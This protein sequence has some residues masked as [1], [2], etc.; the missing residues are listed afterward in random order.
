MKK[1]ALSAFGRIIT[2]VVVAVLLLV[3]SLNISTL[4]SLNA[5]RGGANVQSGYFCAIIGS[6]SMEPTISVHDFLIIKG[7]GAYREGDIV[8]Y[9]S[10][11]GSLVTH[12][13]IEVSDGAYIAQGDANNVP[14]EEIP[15]QRVLGKVVFLIPGV[16][17]VIEAVTAP[18]GIVLSV[19]IFLLVLLIQWIRR[20]INEDKLNEK[21]KANNH[22]EN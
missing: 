18:I 15:G 8:T 7:S 22:T 21:Q 11:K 13:I 1:K 20:D 16:G 14:D 4:L 12:R 2:A 6:G 5:I 3:L 17:G 19:C 10:P 9:V